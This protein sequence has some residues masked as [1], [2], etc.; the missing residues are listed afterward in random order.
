MQK[1]DKIGVALLV[2]LLVILTLPIFYIVLETKKE[3]NQI[4]DMRFYSSCLT[5]LDLCRKY[6]TDGECLKSERIV[7]CLEKLEK[8]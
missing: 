7:K 5:Y 3:L 1:N 8:R 2:G 4:D 6:K